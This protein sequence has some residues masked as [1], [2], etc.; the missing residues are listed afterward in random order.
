MK[1]CTHT[2]IKCILQFQLYW[3]QLS[4]GA[5]PFFETLKQIEF[6]PE[7]YKEILSLY[8]ELQ[9]NTIGTSKND[10]AE[11][12]YDVAC[13]W[14][15]SEDKWRS[16][17][18]YQRWIESKYRK[19]LKIAGIFPLSGTKY[20]AREL[21]PVMMMALKDIKQD[22][23]ILENYDLEPVIVD[24]QCKIDMVMKGVLDIFMN[25]AYKKSFIG[26]LGK[27]LMGTMEIE[28][29][30]ISNCNLNARYLAVILYQYI[31]KV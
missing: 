14:L 31:A 18:N 28:D 30:K 7:T 29:P 15:T 22:K 5:R 21:L 2:D 17:P 25:Q 12:L 6:S 19:K 9:S 3:P 27:L 13:K 4:D 23:T 26:I 10:T 11:L 1:I 16:Q 20:I 8:A 24:G